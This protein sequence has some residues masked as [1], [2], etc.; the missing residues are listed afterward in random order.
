MSYAG[1]VG[2]PETFNSQLGSTTEVQ[3]TE[4]SKYLYESST[5][6]M[7]GTYAD[8]YALYPWTYTLDQGT[9]RHLESGRPTL[10]VAAHTMW[11]LTSGLCGYFEL[12]SEE[13]SVD[14]ELHM[15]TLAEDIQHPCGHYVVFTA[16]AEGGAVSFRHLQDGAVQKALSALFFIALWLFNF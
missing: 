8:V 4:S 6:L 15:P 9:T 12:I 2:K 16:D 11:G 3:A 5:T 14:P 1:E 7:P 10:D 13:V